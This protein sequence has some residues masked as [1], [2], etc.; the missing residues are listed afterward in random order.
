MNDY[1]LICIDMQ[2]GFV[3][4]KDPV[5]INACAKEISFA[6]ENKNPIIIVEYKYNG[7]TWPRLTNLVRDYPFVS[8]IKKNDDDGSEDIMN[9]FYRCKIQPERIR[10]VGV[11][12]DACVLATLYSL[13]TASCFRLEIVRKACN[14]TS[15]AS[16]IEGCFTDL[17]KLGVKVI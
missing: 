4:A 15:A 9:F 6:I 12:T 11:N 16:E 13:Y 17:Q 2:P 7:P 14:S 10:I 1:T 8:F 3:A 5:T